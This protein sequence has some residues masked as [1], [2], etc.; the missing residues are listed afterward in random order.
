MVNNVQ[1]LLIR[2]KEDKAKDNEEIMKF[3]KEQKSSLSKT[4]GERMKEQC[5]KKLGGDLYK[6]L[7][8]CMKNLRKEG[9]ANYDKSEEYNRIASDKDIKS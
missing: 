7:Y 6:K 8:D 9:K 2:N 4:P 3:E 1:E 5:I